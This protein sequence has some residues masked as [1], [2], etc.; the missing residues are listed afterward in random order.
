MDP[1]NMH[2]RLASDIEDATVFSTVE[3]AREHGGYLVDED[4][5]AVGAE[6]LPRDDGF[7]LSVAYLD[8]DAYNAALDHQRDPDWASGPQI[9]PVYAHCFDN[10]HDWM[11]AATDDRFVA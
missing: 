9:G 1:S 8:R 4:E 5:L 11:E 10:V 6:P 7:V 3:E 2:W